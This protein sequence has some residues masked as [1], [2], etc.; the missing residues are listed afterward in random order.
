MGNIFENKEG[1]PNVPIKKDKPR[2]RS[3]FEDRAKYV[4]KNL[5]LSIENL[6]GKKVVDLG[7]GKAELAQWAKEQTINIICLDNFAGYERNVPKGID[8][9]EGEADKLPFPDESL[10]LIISHGSPPGISQDREEVIRIVN[11]AERALGSNGE[12]RF[13]PGSLHPA[14]FKEGELFT[15][16]EEKE[17]S[18]EDRMQRIRENSLEL[19]KSISPNITEE[20]I[21]DEKDGSIKFSYKLKKV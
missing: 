6:R 5:G 20:L 4:L 13:G 12:F 21:E 16:E 11:E 7:A 15:P 8:Y 14:I 17:F 19:L 1:L 3:V 18:T 9:V 10:D 2:E